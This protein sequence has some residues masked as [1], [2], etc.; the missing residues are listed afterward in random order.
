[1]SQLD[2]RPGGLYWTVAV[3]AL[4]W[5]LIGVATYLGSVMSETGTAPAMPAWVTGAYAIAVFAGTFG[6]VGLLL[7][8]AWAVPL[9]ALSLLAVLAQTGYVL[10]GMDTGTPGL[11]LPVLILVIAAYLL[12]ASMSAKKKGWLR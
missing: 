2:N 4:L 6:S 9:F 11:V 5:N 12:W 10:V 3:V 7:R 1:M 8:R